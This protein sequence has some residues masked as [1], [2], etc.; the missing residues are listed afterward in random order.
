MHMGLMLFSIDLD[1]SLIVAP[2][3]RPPPSG[4]I[5]LD[6]DEDAILAELQGQS[7]PLRAPDSG[8]SLSIKG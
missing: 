3:Q 1:E 7:I 5:V 2:V 4:V 8:R 6:H